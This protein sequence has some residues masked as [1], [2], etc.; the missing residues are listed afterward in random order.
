MKRLMKYA[1][2][3][4]IFC[5][6]CLYLVHS[7]AAID[8]VDTLYEQ[9]DTVLTLFETNSKQAEQNCQNIIQSLEKLPTTSLSMAD[10]WHDIGR[11]QHDTRADY[12]QAL[13]C[14]EQA[15]AI[16]EQLISDSTNNDLARSQ[17]M[18]GAT[19]KYLGHYSQ[20]LVHLQKALKTSQL[21]QNN[22]MIAKE[23]LELGDI[24]DYLGDYDQSIICYES[25]YPNILK[26]DRNQAELLNNHFKRLAS[27]YLAKDNHTSALINNRLAI[28]IC[29]DSMPPSVS[30]RFNADIA[31][32]YINM[33]ISY[34]A[35]SKPD[36]AL[37]CL[38]QAF[39]FYKK[40]KIPD[41]DTRLGNVYLEM[42]NLFLQQK[43]ATEALQQHQKAI[44]ILLK[45]NPNHPFLSG[46]YSGMGED[47]LYKNMPKLALSYF[48]KALK[49]V[50]P[51]IPTTMK[52]ITVVTDKCLA[53]MSGI[54][55]CEKAMNQPEKAIITFRQLDT[56]MTNLRTSFKE[57]G[58]KFNLSKEA[59]PIYENA[60]EA[61]LT[62]GDTA[63]ALDFCERNKAVVLREA[64]QDV[65]AKQNLKRAPSVSA[66]EKAL[67]ERISYYQK[68]TF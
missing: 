29:T 39:I 28:R 33:N 5:F 15:F 21:G 19:H 63:A 66:H 14:F 6:A 3:I 31:D 13:Y 58:S 16:R 41:L 34:Q 36:S 20:A 44:D 7:Q 68:T 43:K 51:T 24:Y 11:F 42:G 40:T 56:L 64:L 32:C 57:D 35:I 18:L 55:R 22:F 45:N 62:I 23:Y 54:A 65:N 26:S 53:A 12:A 8:P 27:V 48:E 37:F 46:A 30:D 61:A 38:Q 49:V 25:A 17:F 59:L 67:K 47:F 60:I 9:F 10:L 52:D 2:S 1:L 50:V 4:F